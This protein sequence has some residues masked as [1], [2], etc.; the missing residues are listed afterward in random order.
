MDAIDLNDYFAGGYFVAKSIQRK[1]WMSAELLPETIISLSSCLNKSKIQVFWGWDTDRYKTELEAIG[2]GEEQLDAFRL[3]SQSPI[4]GHPNVFYSLNAAQDFTA[5]FISTKNYLI[6]GVGLPKELVNKFLDDNP[7]TIF[8][9]ETQTTENMI[10]GT[11]LVLSKQQTLESNGNVLGFDI[12]SDSYSDFNHSW[13]C[14]GIHKDMFEQFGIHPN[15]YGLIN[16][17]K[18]ANQVY[19]WIA[20]D[21][22][23]GR[24]SEPEPY[25]P[26]LIVQ[27]PIT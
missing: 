25:Y 16:T 10:D 5:K 26:W 24:R 23:R 7:Q 6:F 27:Y 2:I 19:E 14:S 3:W 17:Y 22:L 13:L 21:E 20:E 12:L 4:V 1:E 8:Y 18:E 11:N 9:P 15:K